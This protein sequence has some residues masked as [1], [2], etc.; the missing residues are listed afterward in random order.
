[1]PRALSPEE[2]ALWRRVIADVRGHTAEVTP[3]RATAAVR[4]HNVVRP[5][6]PL[7]KLKP[8]GP[9]LHGKSHGTTLDGKW[10]RDL[11]T[12][13]VTPDRL[14]DLHGCTLTQAHAHALSALDS[15]VAAGDRLIVVVTGRAPAPDR[16]RIDRP[17]RGIIRASIGDWLRASPLAG[18]IAAIRPAH[19]R[20]GG[21]GALYIVLRR[22][23]RG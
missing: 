8:V 4:Q 1:M 18:R 3:Q 19:A 7:P 2:R 21:A 10:D 23:D 17:L 6:P 11:R 12:G 22:T 16:T 13:K 15:A 5:T 9:G 14:I 20:H